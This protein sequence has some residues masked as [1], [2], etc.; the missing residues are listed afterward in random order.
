MLDPVETIRLFQKQPEPKSFKAGEEIFVQGQPG[1]YM[2]G[3][4]E[5]EVDLIRQ[6][7]L[8]ETLKPGD[9]FGE[10]AL[11]THEGRA[12]TAVARTD[13]K[14]AYMDEHHF[15]FAIDETPTFAL[16]VM[17]SLFNRLKKMS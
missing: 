13:C 10:G 7:Q 12:V 2:Y 17:R 4:L 9:T 3:I 5:G 6:G 16:Q 8:L 14:L 11:I 1:D 15:L